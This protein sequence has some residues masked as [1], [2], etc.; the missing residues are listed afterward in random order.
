[1]KRA[2]NVRRK[3]LPKY[4]LVTMFDEGVSNEGPSDHIFVVLKIV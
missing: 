4:H 3:L 1:M 2:G